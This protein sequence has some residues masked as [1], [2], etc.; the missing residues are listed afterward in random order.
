MDQARSVRFKMGLIG[1]VGKAVKSL[2]SAGTAALD[3]VEMTKR[4][5]TNA[6]AIGP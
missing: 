5:A 2:D 1:Q 6:D 3:P 4:L